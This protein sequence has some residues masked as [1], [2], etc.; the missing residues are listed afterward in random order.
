MEKRKQKKIVIALLF[1]LIF[2]FTPGVLFYLQTFSNNGGGFLYTPEELI[3]REKKLIEVSEDRADLVAL[4]E[5]PNSTFGAQALSYQFSGWSSGGE[6]EVVKSG[7]TFILPGQSKHI[8]EP[9]VVE[10]EID[11]SKG[12]EFEFQVKKWKNLDSYQPPSLW[13]AQPSYEVLE[14]G[15]NYLRV[16]GS[17]IND[18]F[19]RFKTAYVRVLVRDSA[20]K[21]VGVT[22]TRAGDLRPEEQRDFTTFINYRLPSIGKLEFEADTNVF[23]NESFLDQYE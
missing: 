7:E 20:G 4:V 15:R 6:E 17:L 13:V 23:T 9:E 2:I 10:K 21:L 11:F 19:F 3:V 22:K 5:N 1:F 14:E 12:I 8:I 16:E 18:S